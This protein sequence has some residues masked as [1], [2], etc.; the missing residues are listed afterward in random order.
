MARP[1]KHDGAV[2]RRKE[3][4]IWWM[5]YRDKAGCRRLESTHTEDWQEARRQLRER[6][7]ARDNNTLHI[8]RKG[9]QLTFDEWAEFFL[10]NYSKPPIRA[11]GTHEANVTALKRL[12]PVFGPMKMAEI[13]A[14]QN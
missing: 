11:A 8:V 4:N 13:D 10:E 9:E 1:S 3:S 14:M 5:R 2:C 12:R 6:L 7:Q